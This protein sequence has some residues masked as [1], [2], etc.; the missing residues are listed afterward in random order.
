MKA[1]RR[2]LFIPVAAILAAIIGFA[3]AGIFS[4]AYYSEHSLT[5]SVIGLGPSFLGRLLP[6]ATFV[7]LGAWIAPRPRFPTIITLGLLGGVFGWP[8]GPQYEIST[9][10]PTFYLVEGVGAIF[11][12]G[13]GMLIGFAISRRKNEPNQSL[14]TTIMAVTDSAA[15]TPRQP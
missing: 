11:G 9:S 4:W 5:Y 3:W 12:A 7:V 1:I 15:Q 10:G 14:Q 2:L 8:F 6:V 13:V